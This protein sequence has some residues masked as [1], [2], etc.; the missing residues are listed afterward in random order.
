VIW[1]LSIAAKGGVT[2]DIRKIDTVGA[3]NLARD[4]LPKTAGE[5]GTERR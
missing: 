2:I 1:I 3:F 5:I 4:S